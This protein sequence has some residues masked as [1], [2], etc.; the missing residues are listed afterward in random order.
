MHKLGKHIGDTVQ[1][2]G[3]HAKHPYQIVGQVVFPTFGD[4]QPIADGAAFTGAGFAP[5]FDQNNYSRYLVGRF[6][7]G[8][9]RTAVQHHIATNPHLSARPGSALPV[10]VDRLRQIDWFPGTLAALLAGLALIAVGHALVT[11][12]RR[13]RRE[14]ALLKTLGF[15]RRQVRT[16][17]AWQATTIAAA[18][19]IV[20]IP[21]GVVIGDLVWRTV[22]NGLG[23]TTT[24]TIAVP[25]LI[26]IALGGLILVN[27]I[28][29][30]PARTAANTRPAV[31]LRTE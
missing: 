24:P 5:L 16:T 26:L 2:A 17:V 1:A 25:A 30:F 6:T 20:G 8:T 19:L 22:A 15:T 14:L 18:G 9:D 12:V 3:P 27:L 31:A 28:A 29:A 4:V 10:E 21:V 7:P 13:R 23:V 11:A